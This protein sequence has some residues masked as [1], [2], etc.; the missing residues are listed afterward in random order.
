MT[1]VSLQLLSS[2]RRASPSAMCLTLR[3]SACSVSSNESQYQ[4]QAACISAVVTLGTTSAPV[5]LH[6]VNTMYC[7][8]GVGALRLAACDL[9][10]VIPIGRLTLVRQCYKHRA[11]QPFTSS[12]RLHKVWWTTPTV[13]WAPHSMSTDAAWRT[14]SCSTASVPPPWS[15][16][17]V[18]LHAWYMLLNLLLCAAVL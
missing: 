14:C 9:P 13:C 12:C 6:A 17:K 8:S 3:S 4:R 11:S 2:T 10:R 16:I 7:V 1:A 5:M 18:L 15:W